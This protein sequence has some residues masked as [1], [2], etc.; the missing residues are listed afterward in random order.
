MSRPRNSPM[1]LSAPPGNRRG[2]SDLA[3]ANQ[4]RRWWETLT[5]DGSR[6]WLSPESATVRTRRNGYSGPFAGTITGPTEVTIGAGRDANMPLDTVHIGDLAYNGAWTPGYF[7]APEPVTVTASGWLYYDLQLEKLANGG[8]Y[9]RHSLAWAAAFP[10]LTLAWN[11]APV[12][13]YSHGHWHNVTHRNL[14][15]L[16]YALVSGGRVVSWRQT[17]YG[18]IVLTYRFRR[19]TYRAD[20]FILDYRFTNYPTGTAADL[21]SVSVPR[22]STGNE[23]WLGR[24]GGYWV[25]ALSASGLSPAIKIGAIETNSAGRLLYLEE[26]DFVHIGSLEP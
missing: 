19:L 10:T 9:L 13:V 12:P 26:L 5:V 2:W 15:P 25:L 22:P 20:T 16:G 17:Q 4:M 14:V 21:L 23:I 1:A 24:S 11:G 6:V 18:Q 7:D 3:L 8:M